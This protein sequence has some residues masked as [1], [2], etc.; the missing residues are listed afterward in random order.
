MKTIGCKWRRER[1]K[2]REILEIELGYVVDC[3]F[4][5]FNM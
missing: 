2:K 3:M 1:K 4:G 5:V